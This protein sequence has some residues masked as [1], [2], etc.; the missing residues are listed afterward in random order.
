LEQAKH[1]GCEFYQGYLFSKPVNAE[2]AGKLL[3]ADS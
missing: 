1:L 3:G 2:E